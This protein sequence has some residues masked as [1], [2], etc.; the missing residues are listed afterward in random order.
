MLRKLLTVVL[1]LALP[2]IIYF[3]Y[4][5]LARRRP[6]PGPGGEAGWRQAPWTAMVFAGVALMAAVLI[7]LRLFG[8]AVPPGTKIIPDRYI[9]GE[10][11]P[12]RAVD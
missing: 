5:A 12:S 6:H 10:I 8:E 4:A 7:A 9:D 11:K 3:G 1:P 2:F